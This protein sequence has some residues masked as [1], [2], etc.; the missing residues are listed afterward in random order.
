VYAAVDDRDLGGVAADV[1]RVIATIQ[2]SLPKRMSVVVRGQVSSMRSSVEVTG[3]LAEGA[4]IVISPPDDSQGRR[5]GACA[6]GGG[7][8]GSMRLLDP[9]FLLL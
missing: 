4:R 6:A 1:D 9:L 2:P 5:V 7:T 3:G 8:R